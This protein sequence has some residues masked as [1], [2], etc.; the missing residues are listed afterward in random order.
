MNLP[1]VEIRPGETIFEADEKVEKAFEKQA[2]SLVAFD[3]LNTLLETS[4]FCHF[5]QI[6]RSA[7][8]VILVVMTREWDEKTLIQVL[9][10]LLEMRMDPE[11]PGA[12]L[13]FH[14]Y[15]AHEVPR[16]LL[17]LFGS[18]KASEFECRCLL[19]AR[20]GNE[21]RPEQC[22]QLGAV[23]AYLS[24]EYF[25]VQTSLHDPDGELVI[26]RTIDECLR[27][28]GD[29]FEPINSLI[30]LGCLYGE[31]LRSKLPF[32]SRWDFVEQFVPWPG[33][34]FSG[35][36][37]GRPLPGAAA[38]SKEISFNPIGRAIEY[39]R[40]LEPHSLCAAGKELDR[41]C[42]EALGPASAGK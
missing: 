38:M 13:L 15:S 19:V 2:E 11:P 37:A 42:R 33:I 40:T 7:R 34:V 8:P 18:S 31:I 22:Q 14:F 6:E 21:L 12:R 5:F 23:G 1:V 39:Y 4:S 3:S 26:E 20:F 28:D 32:L 17:T 36:T 29:F 41:R 24:H 25:S 30:T 35:S 10:I 9:N 16:V 27:V